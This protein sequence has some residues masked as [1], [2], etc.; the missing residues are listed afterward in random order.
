MS[1]LFCCILGALP[2]GSG[3]SCINNAVCFEHHLIAK[4]DLARDASSGHASPQSNPY[5]KVCIRNS[6]RYGAR[7][8]TEYVDCSTGIDEL[9]VSEYWVDLTWNNS[10]LEAN[11]DACRQKMVDF[12][13]NNGKR[14]VWCKC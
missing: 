9:N 3:D 8:I 13:N 4:H 10:Y 5:L 7:F 11:Q 1:I 12:V 6:C 14:C 2:P